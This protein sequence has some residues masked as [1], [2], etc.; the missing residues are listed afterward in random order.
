MRLVVLV[1][2]AIAMTGFAK[3]DPL[4]PLAGTLRAPALWE[5]YKASF[6]SEGGRIVDN[7]NGNVSHSEGQGYGMLLA[8]AADDRAA[9][10]AIGGWTRSQ[11]MLRE[12]G[13]ASWKWDPSATPHVA[14]RNNATDG[15][16]LIAWALA[17]AGLRWSDAA[18][19]TA[20]LAIARS[21]L[22]QATEPSPY[23]L[24]LKPG[25]SGFD[26]KARQDGPVVNLSYWVF[27]ALDR[28]DAIHPDPVW[29]RLAR[30]GLDL[31]AAARIGPAGLAPDWISLA[32]EDPEPAK[33][34]V[35]T[36]GY[37]AIRIPLYVAWAGGGRKS[38]LAS[39]ATLWQDPAATPSR[40]DVTSGK[41][42]EAM[43]DSGYRAI[44]ALVRCA[45][46][47]DRLPADLQAATVDRYYP[48]TLRLLTLIAARQRY[49]QCL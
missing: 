26:A 11:L 38:T 43:G 27:P 46:S 41:S 2:A 17:E 44:A 32:G 13:L 9:F 42:V 33:G 45:R 39:F 16:L 15:D 7:A 25:V 47:G 28:L 4:P 22:K 48:T 14:D 6:V 21:I 18:Y 30:S 3:A 10:D 31:L 23:G 5:A 35:P 12:D 24:L 19:A 37:D 36:F 49:P 20:S 1:V 40:I 34:F 8:V 29:Q